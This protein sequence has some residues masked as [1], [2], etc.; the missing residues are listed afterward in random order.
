M[1][2]NEKIKKKFAEQCQGPFMLLEALGK[3]TWKTKELKTKR[4]F[5][6]HARRLRRVDVDESNG[7]T[8]QQ[9]HEQSE[10]HAPD[11]SDQASPTVESDQDRPHGQMDSNHTVIHSKEQNSHHS[12]YNLRQRKK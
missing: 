9:E 7:T 6:L 10:A 3:H 12:G 1:F 8:V 4:D 5:I 2:V 11:Q